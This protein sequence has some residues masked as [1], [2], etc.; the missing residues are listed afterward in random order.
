MPRDIVA[1]VDQLRQRRRLRVAAHLGHQPLEHAAIVEPEL[2]PDQ[3]G[4]LD[5]VGAF[6]DR[7][8]PRVAEM[9]RGAG[10]LDIA[11]AAVD[12]DA[13]AGDL[14]AEIGAVRLGERGQQVE[15]R[16]APRASPALARST[17]PQAR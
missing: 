12:L 16:L 4:G 5:A 15:P 2:A 1:G 11:H 8:D 14:V 9:L 13:E 6:V 7:R 17:W 3:I 10:L